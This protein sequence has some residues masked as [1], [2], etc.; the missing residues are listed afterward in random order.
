MFF[1]LEAISV[2]IYYFPIFLPSLVFQFFLKKILPFEK[3][4]VLKINEI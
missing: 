3:S 4:K 1:V 2:S